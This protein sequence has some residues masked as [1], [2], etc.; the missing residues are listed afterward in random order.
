MLDGEGVAF[1]GGGVHELV[2]DGTGDA[3]AGRGAAAAGAGHAGVTLVVQE[4]AGLDLAFRMGGGRDQ[5][6]EGEDGRF[7]VDVFP[8]LTHARTFRGFAPEFFDGRD[9]SLIRG[10][11]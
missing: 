2:H 5:G 9:H 4:E 6:H 1:E 8:I 7:D 11:P 3:T 10:Q